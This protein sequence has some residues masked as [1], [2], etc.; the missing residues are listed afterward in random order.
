MSHSA[1]RR[2]RLP[3]Q[4][5]LVYMFDVDGV[6][7][8]PES[9]RANPRLLAFL[10]NKLFCNKPV[11][12]A[13]TRDYQWVEENIISVIRPYLSPNKLDNL[14]V[15]C[16]KGAVTITHENG[17]K[18]VS[19]DESLRVPE[20]IGERLKEKIGENNPHIFYYPKETLFT[21]EIYGGDN[22]EALREQNRALDELY[23]WVTSE[24]IQPDSPY[25]ADRTA[26]A[27]DIFNKL[28]NK[29]ISA[30]NFVNYLKAKGVDLINK[31]FV[32]VGDGKTDLEMAIGLHQAGQE[33]AFAW[34]GRGNPPQ[35]N[36]FPVITP[37][38]NVTNDEGTKDLLAFLGELSSFSQT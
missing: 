9:K 37:G 8:N 18:V 19:Y 6:I 35:D 26:I 11:A 29:M 15:S 12:F 24:L 32:A 14:F 25:K 31:K 38:T 10:A 33:V 4:P 16:E 7:T 21:A 3:Q 13:T 17:K 20:K 28:G 23:V 22:P 27:I 30:Q 2:E 36:R 1:E 5:E 34:V